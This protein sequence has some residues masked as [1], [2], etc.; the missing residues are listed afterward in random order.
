MICGNCKANQA[1]WQCDKCERNFCNACFDEVHVHL[2]KHEGKKLFAEV[3]NTM[4]QN[5]CPDHNNKDIEFYCELDN[6]LTCSFCMLIGSHVGHEV[7]TLVDKNKSCAEDLKRVL[8]EITEVQKRMKYTDHLL[9]EAIPTQKVDISKYIKNV[10]DHFHELHSL[11]QLRETELISQLEDISHH[12]IQPLEKMKSE[13]SAYHK[14]L[15][16]VKGDAEKVVENPYLAVSAPALL[17]KLEEFK[18]LPYYLVGITDGK[19]ESLNIDFTI[20]PEFDNKI[21]DLCKISVTFSPKFTLKAKDELPENYTHEMPEKFSTYD[22]SKSLTTAESFSEDS[23]SVKSHKSSN[24]MGIQKSLKCREFTRNVPEEVVASH[25]I[26]PS[27]FW[28]QKLSDR[29]K[30]HELS[31]AMNRWCK[32]EGKKHHVDSVEKGDLY[33]VQYSADKRWYRG[34]V[35][36]VFEHGESFDAKAPDKAK[37]PE[38]LTKNRDPMVE[39][40]YIDYGNSEIVPMTKFRHI[41]ARFLNLPGLAKECSL[42]GIQPANGVDWSPVALSTF[43]KFVEKKNLLMQTYEERNNILFVDLSQKPDS[44]IACD[45]PVSVRDALVFLE[46]AVFPAGVTSPGKNSRLER[47]FLPPEQLRAN[48]NICAILSHVNSPSYFYI[49]QLSTAPYLSSLIFDMNEAYSDEH[50]VLFHGIYAPRVNMICAA[51]FTLD[52]QWYRAIVKSLPGGT[53]VEVQYIDFGNTEVV[54]YKRLRKLF[55]KF[56]KLNIQAIPC[57]L[58]DIAPKGERWT[59]EAVE[60]MTKNISKKKVQLK[61]LGLIPGENIANVVLSYT[62]GEFEVCVNALMVEEGLA[63]STGAHSSCLARVRKESSKVARPTLHKVSSPPVAVHSMKPR[64]AEIEPDKQKKSY[65]SLVKKYPTTDGKTMDVI[66]SNVLTP[67]LFHIRIASDLE[68]K[69]TALMTEMQKVYENSQYEVPE[70]VIGKSYVAFSRS[71]RKWCRANIVSKLADDIFEVFLVDFGSTEQAAKKDIQKLLENFTHDE[72]FALRCHLEGI[73][74]AG[75]SSEWSQVSCEAFQQLVATHEKFLVTTK[76][77]LEDGSLGVELFYEELVRGGALEPTKIEFRSITKELV[78]RGLALKIRAKSNSVSPPKKNEILKSPEKNTCHKE[79]NG[80][81]GEKVSNELTA[82]TP[83]DCCESG[84][85][86]SMTSAENPP[87]S[88]ENVV[89]VNESLPCKVEEVVQ[90]NEAII[91]KPPKNQWLPRVVPKER[92]FK[93]LVTNIDHTGSI[94][95]YH[96]PE[97]GTSPV[98]TIVSALQFKFLSSAYEPPQEQLPIGEA[99]IAKFDMD[100]CW[101]RAEVI[102]HYPGRCK[103]HFVDYG[104]YERV[105]LTDIRTDIILQTIP[106]QCIECK[107]QGIELGYDGNNEV[108]NFLHVQLVDKTVEV[109]QLGDP[110]ELGRI[111]CNIIT[112]CGIGV[113]ELLETMNFVKP[114]PAINPPCPPTNI[115]QEAI[116]MC[117]TFKKATELQEGD[118]FPVCVSQINSP[119]IVYIQKLKISNPKSDV[120]KKHNEEHEAFLQLIEDLQE[121]AESFPPVSDPMPGMACCAKYS[122]DNNWYRCEVTNLGENDVEVLYVDYG[123]SETLPVNNLRSPEDFFIEFPVQVHFCKIHGINP[124][125]DEAS[126]VKTFLVEKLMGENEVF[127]KV[128]VPGK[129]SEVDLMLKDEDGQFKLVYEDLIKQNLL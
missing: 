79:Q 74:P 112:S 19:D 33:I 86:A 6:K 72:S 29:R 44:S 119:N 65:P 88:K 50:T 17:K 121:K 52:Q 38:L 85:S 97:Q 60:W 5:G 84:S 96:V 76:G 115:K 102:E 41:Q 78:N 8:T 66:V 43:T 77:E 124:S 37:S 1:Q 71:L 39:V 63:E 98:P 45:T 26:S 82:E 75:G 87:E 91:N 101:Y 48:S 93:G 14:D 64:S 2:K 83:V 7:K 120:E 81:D 31:E 11:L 110:D 20:D 125:E 23:L 117:R 30:L 100:S 4:V 89:I 40:I 54:H 49:Q 9:A 3:Y 94:H 36:K 106:R 61:S 95:L 70:C 55:D 109:E 57:K 99:C 92:R 73:I 59:T 105:L 13:V 114:S 68:K 118:I 128:V 129:I 42:I 113:A 62:E 80:C 90:D 22:D 12:N 28:V 53:N 58:A 25:I 18:T 24:H 107:I 56:N 51:Q 16:A 27:S 67:A 122:Y 127:A 123:N 104:N 116:R 15:I 47:Q 69:L 46:H 10:H 111:P 35:K 103:V 34:R 21:K 126:T 108:L 32:Y